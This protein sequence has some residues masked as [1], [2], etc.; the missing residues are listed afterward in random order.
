MTKYN[1][2]PKTPGP[3]DSLTSLLP[4]DDAATANW[5]NEWRMPTIEE[6]KE[7]I[8]NCYMVWTDNFNGTD[9]H[10]TI[11]YKAKSSSDKGLYVRRGQTPSADYNNSDVHIF[12][13]T[14]NNKVYRIMLCDAN[15][16]DE[17]NIKIRFRQK[18]KTDFWC[19]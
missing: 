19:G 7:I 11:C 12:I 1:Y 9:V 14:N 15:Y 6:Q 5:G 13:A 17:A 10:G 4:E 16:Q 2:N 8:D 3:R 18:A